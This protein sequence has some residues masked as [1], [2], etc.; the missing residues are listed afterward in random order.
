M[1]HSRKDISYVIG[2]HRWKAS[3]LDKNGY[4]ITSTSAGPGNNQYDIQS[5]K[6][7]DYLSGEK[8][9]Y[10][11]GTC[12]TTGY[13]PEGHQDNLE[14]ISGTWKFAGVQCEACHGPGSRHAESSLKTDITIE[15]NNCSNCHST[16]PLNIIPLQGVFLDG[17]TETNQLLKSKMKTLACTDCHNPHLSSEKSIKQSCNVCHQDIAK[18]YRESYMYKVG[19]K[20]TDCHMPPAEIIAGGDPKSFR[21]DFKSHLFKIIHN[22][23]FPVVSVNG[24]RTNPGYLSVDYSC[25][26]CHNVFENREWA[27]RFSM[28]SHRIKITTDIKIMR[29]QK[30]STYIGFLFAL[31]ALLSG[32]YLK[33][34]L[35]TYLAINKKTII[36]IHRLCGWISFSLYIFI[37]VLCLYF[38]FPLDHPSRILNVGWFL[39][40]P[41]NGVIGLILYAG[42]IFNIRKFKKGWALQGILWGIAIFLSWLIQL[43]TVVFG[44]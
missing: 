34:L 25:M 22:K 36:S 30:V 14:G 42:K 1:G 13:S 44:V 33:N 18:I 27:V 35:L 9:P 38:H 19:V 39:I 10:N 15:R 16:K 23:L 24:Q 37:S 40:H 43:G 6:W 8:I 21:A 2:S 31:T 17:Y 4:L 20:C 7:V 12:H 32:L 26:R 11:C 41:I 29:L 28:F 5:K 3:F